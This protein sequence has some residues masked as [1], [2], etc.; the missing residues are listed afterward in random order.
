MSG[1]TQRDADGAYEDEQRGDPVGASVD[2]VS[3]KSRGTDSSSRP[4]P[5]LR[6]ELVADRTD[7]GGRHDKPEPLDR[8]RMEQPFDRLVAGE[9]G[10]EGDEPD[11]DESCE[12][13]CLP[14][15][16]GETT[17]RHPPTHTKGQPQRDRGQPVR[18]IVERIA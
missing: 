10:R 18:R 13:L 17:G 14:E 4:D 9:R 1:S 15:P 3:F 11:H 12:V 5:V 16:I 2:T 8:L 7:H 6:D